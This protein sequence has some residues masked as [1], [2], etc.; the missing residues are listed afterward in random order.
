VFADVRV[1]VWLIGEA[2]P[3]VGACPFN[4]EVTV[5]CSV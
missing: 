2:D 4:S 1:A 5:L 3:D